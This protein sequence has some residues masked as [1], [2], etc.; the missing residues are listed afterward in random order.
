MRN[1]RNAVVVTMGL[2]LSQWALA[3]IGSRAEAVSLAAK[4]RV[5]TQEMLKQYVL[6]G[7]GVRSRT[8][9]KKLD[10]AMSE[11]DQSLQELTTYSVIDTEAMDI[12]EQAAAQWRQLSDI[13]RLAPSKYNVSELHQGTNT[14]DRLLSRWALVVK[15][16]NTNDLGGQDYVVSMLQ[17]QAYG[18]QRIAA[19]Y[20]IKAM[21][22]STFDPVAYSAA[23]ED[24][25]KN[26]NVMK[27]L[28]YI[29]GGK[30]LVDKSAREFQRVEI[31]IDLSN[32]EGS[33]TPN[34]VAKATESI[35]EN[36]LQL[37][38]MYATP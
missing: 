12:M 33:Y 27:G 30:V 7:L 19:L 17:Q 34:L 15:P 16:N 6:W 21:E 37:E 5:L 29:E 25:A 38:A 20:N 18:A 14:L 24:Y 9:Q 8:A 28:D 3:D 23:L 10:K 1:I 4:E 13:Y 22:V 11:F 26:T 2:L 35:M 32:K 31:Q 36:M